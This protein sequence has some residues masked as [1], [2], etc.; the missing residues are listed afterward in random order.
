MFSKKCTLLLST[1]ELQNVLVKLKNDLFVDA[2]FKKA[3]H[4]FRPPTKITSLQKAFFFGYPPL[5]GR[6]IRQS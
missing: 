1:A 5:I 4:S 2:F 3:R 6:R